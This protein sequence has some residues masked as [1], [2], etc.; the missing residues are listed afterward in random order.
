MSTKHVR[1]CVRAKQTLE[2]FF[3][4]KLTLSTNKRSVSFMM[5]ISTSRV[6]L[7]S[8]H[9]YWLHIR[10]GLLLLSIQITFTS[11]SLG[12]NDTSKFDHFGKNA[13]S[14]PK[15]SSNH[16][17]TSKSQKIQS[18]KF[19]TQSQMIRSEIT[20]F[21]QLLQLGN[22][23]SRGSVSLVVV[24]MTQKS[25]KR[26]SHSPPKQLYFTLAAQEV[27]LSTLNYRAG[28]ALTKNNEKNN[29][30]RKGKKASLVCSWKYL[31][32]HS[33][34]ML[35][36]KNRRQVL[37]PDLVKQRSKG[38]LRLALQG[39]SDPAGGSKSSSLQGRLAV[40]IYRKLVLAQKILIK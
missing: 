11:L 25:K 10:W 20:T 36:D 28:Q 39:S 27:H 17:T 2:V 32:N 7:S 23:F 15:F 37:A 3:N 21:N 38:N 31:G 40:F 26:T 22:Y 30:Y 29:W 9:S 24:L 18:R 8:S 35:A 1:V 6:S 34:W 5:A 16:C 14:Y 33:V 12:D 19:L 4:S 13:F